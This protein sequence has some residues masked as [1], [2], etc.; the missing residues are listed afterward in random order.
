MTLMDELRLG[1]RLVLANTDPSLVQKTMDEMIEQIRLGA[2]D[3]GRAA[4]GDV[5]VMDAPTM[6]DVVR[7]MIHLHARDIVGEDDAELVFEDSIPYGD[8]IATVPEVEDI[9]QEH[10]RTHDFLSGS[11]NFWDRVGDAEQD[12]AIAVLDELN[13]N[14]KES[15]GT[16]ITEY[17]E[18]LEPETT[19]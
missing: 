9:L 13:E 10:V 5:P 4:Y 16:L 19:E 8:V 18:G 3:A 14:Q 17:I 11:D 1:A 6:R 7:S 12:F 2:K 15:L